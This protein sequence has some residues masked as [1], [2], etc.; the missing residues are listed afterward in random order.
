VTAWRRTAALGLGLVLGAGAAGCGDDEP[1]LTVLAAASLTEP[2]STLVERFEVEHPGVRVSLV[3]ESSAT[4]AQ[5]A[6]ER[7]PGDVLATADQRTMDRAESRG[8]TSAG[9]ARFAGN[10]LVLAVPATNPAGIESLDDLDRPGVDYLTCVTTAPCGAAAR[11]LLSRA[12]I[13]R[14]PASQEVDVRAVL[15]KVMTGEADAGLVYRTDAI[16]A[17]DQ[18][19][20]FTVPGADARPNTYWVARTANVADAELAQAWIDLLTGP[21]GRTVLARAGFV[22]DE[23]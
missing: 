6:V 22:L 5:M 15:G 16:S 21:E 17:T 18:V 12:G 1:T 4:L 10:V 2:F 8:G 14:S 3:F 7:A 9:A 11:D 20:S 23:G 19:Q 13:T